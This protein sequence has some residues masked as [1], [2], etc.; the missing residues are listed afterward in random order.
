M[1]RIALIRDRFLNPERD[2]QDRLFVMLT[3]MI[4]LAILVVFI[5]DIILGEDMTEII[6]LG[7]ALVL[8]PT[9]GMLL[10][11]M[12]GTKY[13]RILLAAAA[14]FVLLPI[15]FFYGG[16]IHGGTIIWFSITY[17]YIGMILSGRMKLIMLSLLTL[18]AV[19]LCY[20]SNHYP[21]LIHPHSETMALFDQTVAIIVVGLI[22]YAMVW[23]QNLLYINEKN[24]A[25]EEAQKVEEMSRAQNQF[26]SNMSHEIR[27]PINT[28]IGLNEM[29]LREDISEEV[30]EDA[31]NI[32][33]AGKILLH[34]INDILD[35][36]KIQS[37]QMEINRTPYAP[38]DMLSEIVAM[39]WIRARDKGLA[40][41]VNVSPDIP[42]EL[43]GD[44]VRIKQILINLINNAI[45][46]TR[47]GSVTLTVEAGERQGDDISV[48]YSVTD[49]GIGIK[50]ES[51][52]HLFSVFRRVDEVNNRYIE[53]TGLGLSIVRQL[54]DMMGG[55]ITVN[56]V[57]TKGSTFMIEIP[58][59]VLDPAA[60]G[61]I[62]VE[63]RHGI[64]ARDQYKKVFEAPDARLL[65][66]DDNESN[67]L[68]VTK[69]LRD[70]KIRIDTAM[71]GREALKL[72]L[73]NEYHVIFMDH[74]MPEMDGIECHRR[75]MEQTGGRSR[76]AKV[77]ALTANA[78]EDNKQLYR[79]EGF[80]G[81][82]EKPV[83]GGSLERELYR[84]LP[85]DLV[86]KVGNVEEITE[87]TMQWMQSHE[88]KRTVAVTTETVADL[89]RELIDRYGIRTLPH[90]VVTDE[91]TFRDGLEIDTDGLLTYMED[92]SRKIKTD[93]FD[94]SV[95]ESFFADV[96]S[97]ANNIIHVVVSSEVENSSYPAAVEAAKA[98]G[99][100]TVIDCRHLSSGQGLVVLEACRLAEE[101]KTPQE[102]EQ[103]L[104]KFIGRVH[105]SFVVN[106]LDFLARA[107]QIS[108]RIANLT[109]AFMMRPV[110][111]MKKGHL[112]VGK[113]YLGSK[114]RCWR[115]YMD[116]VLR[117]INN[118]D[119]SIL[120]VTYV[121]LSNREKESIRTYI[122]G[123]MEFDEIY[124]QKASP[125]IAVNCGAGTFGLLYRENV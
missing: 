17:F 57:Y 16:G 47:E 118:I 50:K 55:K 115:K 52:P 84:L 37:G 63:K 24:R 69:L 38:G 124:F 30:A 107:G 11:K 95:H 67:L 88:R 90:L 68:V 3:D 117:S 109:R 98:F 60:I 33:A 99:N 66:V 49:T 114:E 92:V 34:L 73:N 89:P 113:I 29:I 12:V 27:T 104:A 42:A 59:K 20:V 82:I 43:Y 13:C 28:I 25:M 6:L 46:Y 77:V 44:E 4:L 64:N 76:S 119:T 83:S 32:Q 45:K 5:A 23:L 1:K 14:V 71:S 15:S 26:F 110:L 94:A 120:F 21:E 81:Y 75:I 8:I 48:I 31:V 74:L 100:V 72:T 62:D 53:G 97:S 7:S 61:E 78:G 65:V 108:H 123:K 112:R 122:Q 39:L 41:H 79:K 58:Q 51:I 36:S 54:V 40:F 19:A 106:E 9:A 56:S 22:L 87:E 70:T 35:M 101:G 85:G 18:L 102:I 80:D 96:L 93:V 116:S 103:A 111:V 86:H 91:G 125:A 2:F 105:T 10:M 121:G